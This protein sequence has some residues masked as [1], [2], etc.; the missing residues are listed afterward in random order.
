MWNTLLLFINFSVNEDRCSDSR[1]AYAKSLS[2][3]SQ[4]PSAGKGPAF[5]AQLKKT[6]LSLKSNRNASV[7]SP[8]QL[9][10]LL[11]RGTATAQQEKACKAI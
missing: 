11:L 4:L 7:T 6:H 3:C 8:S 10:R 5:L 2:I 9:L 1:V